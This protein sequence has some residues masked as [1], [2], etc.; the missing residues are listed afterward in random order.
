MKIETVHVIKEVG[1]KDEK[2]SMIKKLHRQF[3]H[4]S[5]KSLKAILKNAEVLDKQSEKIVEDIS[6][7]CEICLRYKRTPSTPVVSLPLANDG[8]KNFWRC[9]FSSLY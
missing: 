4:P 8:F 2:T 6:S 7:I 3:G 5:I 1:S 9:I